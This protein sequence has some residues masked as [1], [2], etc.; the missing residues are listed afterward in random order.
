MKYVTVLVLAFLFAFGAVLSPLAMVLMPW[1]ASAIF[2]AQN[3]LCG[4]AWLGFDGSKTISAT[5]GARLAAGDDCKFCERLCAVLHEV[6][7]D[8]HCKK[9]AK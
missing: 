4:A 7:E 5:C 3:R 9:E 1:R 8:D 2:K 6:L